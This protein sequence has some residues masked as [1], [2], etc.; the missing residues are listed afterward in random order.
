ML[1]VK[2]YNLYQYGINLDNIDLN[3]LGKELSCTFS[4]HKTKSPYWKRIFVLDQ[5]GVSIGRITLENGQVY[6]FK[7][8]KPDYIDTLSEEDKIYCRLDSILK[9]GH[10]LPSDIYDKFVADAKVIADKDLEEKKAWRIAN[11]PGKNK[12]KG[13]KR[14]SERWL[15][16]SMVRDW[17]NQQ[18]QEEQAQE[19]E[20]DWHQQINNMYTYTEDG[21]CD[22]F[23]KY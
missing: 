23:T 16:I 14:R 4:T 11:P 9:T 17:C 22:G 2:P 10:I 13:L 18:I 20:D 15:V 5:D 3:A 6:Y 21:F 1:N 8:Y 12:R 19:A 7:H